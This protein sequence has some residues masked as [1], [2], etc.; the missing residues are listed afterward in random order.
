MRADNAIKKDINEAERLASEFLEAIEQNEIYQCYTV[1]RLAQ[2]ATSKSEA[3]VASATKALFTSLIEHLADSFDAQLVPF[4]NRLMAQLIHHCRKSEEG[5]PLDHQLNRFGLFTE[6]DLIVRAERLSCAQ[7]IDPLRIARN[8]VKLIIVLSRVTVG[9]DVAVTSVVIERLKHEFPDSEIILA[10]GGKASE[11]FGGDRRLSFY[12]V[13]YK[14]AGATLDRLLNWNQILACVSDLTNEM[15]A[16]QCLIIDPDSRLTQLGLLPLSNSAG[17]YL[18]FPSRSYKSETDKSLGELTSLWLDEVFETHLV[19]SPHVNLSPRDTDLG[20][21][22]VNR[23]RESDERRLIAVNFG[24]G[25]NPAKRLGDD[26][27]RR[28]VGG[29]IE[30]GARVIFDKGFGA[31]EE[32]RADEVI[33]RVMNTEREGRKMRVIEA[34]EESLNEMLDLNDRLQIDLLVWRGRIGLFASLISKSDLYI[35]YDSAFQHI[36]AALGVPC[37]DV[38]AGFSSA[39][40]PYRWRPA[41]SRKARVIALDT[42]NIQPDTDA[43][44]ADVLK[45]AFEI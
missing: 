10:G 35:G 4:Y 1:E 3:H 2:M 28:L 14:R 6:D 16:D 42:L 40:M 21:E 17:N 45:S 36:A 13:D 15:T 5:K 31:Q 22:V 29:L 18:F 33:R 27:E 26:F 43:V 44:L 32:Q 20:G 34:N 25:E 24:T 7:K 30:K 38:F 12:N 11:L 23:L 39:R 9:A 19:L 8:T 41:G 37:I